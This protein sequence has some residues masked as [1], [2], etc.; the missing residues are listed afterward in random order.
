MMKEV[1]EKM[2]EEALC[3]SIFPL[4]GHIEKVPLLLCLVWVLK[5]FHLD[6]S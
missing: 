1:V 6:P 2:M 5:C 4:E 3:L